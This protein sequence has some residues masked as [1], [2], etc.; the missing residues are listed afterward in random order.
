MRVKKGFWP[1]WRPEGKLGNWWFLY[2]YFFLG[3]GGANDG[4]LLSS[5]PWCFGFISILL[6]LSAIALFCGWLW[7]AWTSFRNAPCIV[8]LIPSPFLETTIVNETFKVPWASSFNEPIEQLLIKQANWHLYGPKGGEFVQAS[9]LLANK[10]II[11]I[12]LAYYQSHTA[13][14][15]II[16]TMSLLICLGIG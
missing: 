2:I 12:I 3:G 11:K 16:H 9:N 15:H 5:P 6:S 4:F 14:L 1:F 10:I 13:S 7:L 8:Q